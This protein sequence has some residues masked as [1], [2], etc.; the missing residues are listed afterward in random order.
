LLELSIILIHGS[1]T[2]LLIFS[3]NLLEGSKLFM[4]L[5]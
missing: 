2:V 1:M 5:P 3:G 4:S